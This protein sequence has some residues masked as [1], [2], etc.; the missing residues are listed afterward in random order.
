MGN[1]YAYVQFMVYSDMCE[2]TDFLQMRA[3]INWV[4]CPLIFA[5]ILA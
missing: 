4:L 1:A 3:R 5:R 2:I